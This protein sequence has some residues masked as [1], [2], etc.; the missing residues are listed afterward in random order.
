M[1][2]LGTVLELSSISEEE[3]FLGGL[4]TKG[5]DGNNVCI[6]QDDVMQVAFHVATMMPTK[7]S[8]PNCNGKKRHIGNNYVTIVY[9]ES[10]QPYSLNTITVTTCPLRHTHSLNTITGQFNHT[11]VEVVPGYHSANS[12]GVLCRPE[13][14]DFVGGGGNPRLVSDANLPILV[15]Q[16][17]LHA[18]LASIVW[19]SLKRPPH[20]PF[21]SSW[22]ERLRKNRKI[23]M[24]QLEG[25]GP[26]RGVLGQGLPGQGVQGGVAVV[27]LGQHVV[28]DVTRERCLCSATRRPPPSSSGAVHRY[29]GSVGVLEME[30]P[31]LLRDEAVKSMQGPSLEADMT[32]GGEEEKHGERVPT[33]SQRRDSG[34]RESMQR[35]EDPTHEI[36]RMTTRKANR[37]EGEVPKETRTD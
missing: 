30:L 29:G 10:G 36:L 31:S 15:R 35:E 20:S 28:Q 33:G 13:L 32:G 12:V 9:N 5:S 11:T 1:Q 25:G 2:G 17:S 21:A 37:E 26:R 18:D 4:D 3:V 16:I 19:E 27:T 7:D 22:L 6:W 23:K 8:D 34:P 24:C 14:T